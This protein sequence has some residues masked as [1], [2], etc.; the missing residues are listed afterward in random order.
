MRAICGRYVP[1]LAITVHRDARSQAMIVRRI[2]IYSA[3]NVL[4]AFRLHAPAEVDD[5]VT[6]WLTEAYRVGAQ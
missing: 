3:R 5:E 4:H 1:T 6:A 2:E